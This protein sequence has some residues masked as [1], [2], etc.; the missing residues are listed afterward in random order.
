M[1]DWMIIVTAMIIGTLILSS[2]G[3]KK[4]QAPAAASGVCMLTG[5]VM[6]TDSITP[7]AGAR[8]YEKD[9]HRGTTLSDSAGYFQ[10]DNVTF[11]K[12]DILVEKEGY[13]PTSVSLE[14]TG[15]LDHPI[16]TRL[17]I[18]NK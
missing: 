15:K 5:R 3:E 14:Y 17:V 11:E 6:E 18:L 13:R 8:I 1:K 9:H 2:C 4:D 16:V 10:L 7:I 12:H